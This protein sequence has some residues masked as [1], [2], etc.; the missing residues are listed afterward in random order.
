MIKKMEIEGIH[1]EV[2]EDLRKYVTR[3]IGKLDKYM[4]RHARESAHAEVK[5]KEVT[6]KKK[7]QYTC[8]VILHLPHENIMTKETT[9]NIFA[10]VDIVETKLKNQLKK[11]KEK[12][13]ILRGHTRRVVNKIRSRRTE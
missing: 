5:L 8:E 2:S 3:K 9:L 6:S 10:A 11:Y 4:P 1:T 12:H 13:S 7:N